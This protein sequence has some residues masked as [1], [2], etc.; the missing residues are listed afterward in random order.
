[1]ISHKTACNINEF[2]A[3]HKYVEIS[4]TDQGKD[5]SKVNT[6]L[7]EKTILQDGVEHYKLLNNGTII[8]TINKLKAY[9]IIHS[10][11]MGSM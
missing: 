9:S 2:L 4:R 1:M 6:F 3:E 10:F 5:L 11:A 7:V 8:I